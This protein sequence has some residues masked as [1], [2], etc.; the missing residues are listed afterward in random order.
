MLSSVVL[1]YFPKEE[2]NI[3]KRKGQASTDI[4]VLNYGMILNI[5]KDYGIYTHVKAF[6]IS[7]AS[8]ANAREMVLFLTMLFQNFQHFYPK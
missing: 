6:H 5:L 2:K 7:P 3:I 1:S 4:K 8:A